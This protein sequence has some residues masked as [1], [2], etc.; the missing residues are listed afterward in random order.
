VSETNR[1]G[2]NGRE[3]R[4]RGRA[5]CVRAGGEDRKERREGEERNRVCRMQGR[6]DCALGE[7]EKGRRR[8]RRRREEE[9]DSAERGEK[10]QGRG[11]NKEK[12]EKKRKWGSGRAVREEEQDKRGINGKERKER[13]RQRF[14]VERGESDTWQ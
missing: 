9:K 10:K 3:K 14:A 8:R 1:G 12:K 11:E 6:V 7:E 2:R 5:M 13:E 4:G